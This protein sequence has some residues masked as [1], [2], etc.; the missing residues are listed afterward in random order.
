VSTLGPK[1]FSVV[2]HITNIRVT[3]FGPKDAYWNP[4]H[5][6]TYHRV[7][8]FVN[9]RYKRGDSHI[10]VMRFKKALGDYTVFVGNMTPMQELYHFK[11][12]V[13]ERTVLFQPLS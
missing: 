10:F 12:A 1:A 5:I 9:L 6:A 8:K 7:K 4:S 13:L 2:H 3:Y 11:R